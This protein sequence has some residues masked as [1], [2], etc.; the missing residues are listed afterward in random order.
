MA[1]I[2]RSFLRGSRG[3]HLD[4]WQNA[5][6]SLPG[7]QPMAGSRPRMATALLRG[8]R[9]LLRPAGGSWSVQNDARP[10]GRV[11]DGLLRWHQFRRRCS[12]AGSSGRCPR[13]PLAAGRTRTA[14]EAPARINEKLAFRTF[15][16]APSM[17]P[18]SVVMATRVCCN[19]LLFADVVGWRRCARH[20]ECQARLP[21]KGHRSSDLI[22]K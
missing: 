19:Q 16:P 8:E 10:D 9:E 15:A 21:M 14:R 11:I 20:A 22:T 13:A 5:W 17:E 2:A 4:K 12:A 1:A 6:P 7:L 3:V 18:G